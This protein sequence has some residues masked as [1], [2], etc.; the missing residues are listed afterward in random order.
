[1]SPG[2]RGGLEGIDVDHRI[3]EYEATESIP[4]EQF[5]ERARQV[6]EKQINAGA[7]DTDDERSGGDRLRIEWLES[8]DVRLHAT[9]YVGL[10]T[11][12]GGLTIQIDPKVE[13]ADLLAMLQFAQGIEAETTDEETR[14]EGGEE[15]IQALATLF[16]SELDQVL[17]RGLHSSYRR[18]QGTETHVRGRIDVQ[19]QLQRHGTQP[20]RFEC[21]YDALTQDTVLNQAV[22]YATEVLLRL[23]GRDQVGQALE[24]HKQ[25]LQRQVELRPIRLVELEKV[26][27]KRLAEY[28]EDLFR[29]TKLVL[30]GLYIDELEAGGRSS[31]SLLVNM[32]N[33]F[34]SVV[35]EG[36]R[37]A[38]A[39]KDVEI[40]SQARRHELFHSG[41][42]TVSIKPDVAVVDGD[43][44]VFVGDAK[45]K[46][47]SKNRRAPA[48]NDLY[49]IISY[50]VAYDGPGVLFYP[51]QG[52]DVASTYESE[53]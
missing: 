14:F 6:I 22:L 30:N 20:T 8:G 13:G 42:R 7:S 51:D 23:V 47:D 1:M 19:R 37:R 46:V 16:E 21:S 31:S 44:T 33:I 35:A 26:E 53:L 38:Y 24:R 48:N 12:P 29:L 18:A 17:N 11:L 2:V 43:E 5:P 45:W 27:I 10:V 25:Q 15:F 9:S 34:E 32:N 39:D 3:Q 40:L 52:G 28:Y 49:Q 50:Q 41:G 36:V 4:R